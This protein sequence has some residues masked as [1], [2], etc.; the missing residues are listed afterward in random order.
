[1]KRVV[2]TG[3]G[4]VTALGDSWQDFR[5]ALET[6]TSA[7][8]KIEEWGKFRDFNTNL[9]GPVENFETPNYPRKKVRSMSRVSLMATKATE[10]ALLDAA[11]LDDPIIQSGAMGVS[12]GSCT[13]STEDTK[14]FAV[15]L[16]N[17][18]V[19]GATATTYIRMM[20]HT[21]PVNIGVFF[22]LKGR[23]IPTSSAC[24]SG[25]QGIGYAY[26][27]IK[28]GKQTL[29]AAGGAE[30]LCP[31][32]AAV[33]DSLYATSTK[34]DTPHL[35]PSPFDK[36]RDGLVIGEGAGTLILE[37]LDHALARGANIYAELVGFGTNS[38]GGHVTQPNAGTMKIAM[39]MALQ[40]ANLQAS[41]IG[42]INGHGTATD[43]GDIAE[44]R[45]TYEVFGDN[46]P[47]STLKGNIGHTLG[48]CGAIEAWAS[49]E[50]MRS[51]WIAPTL[52]LNEPDEACAALDYVMG[53][54]RSR[55]CEYIMSNNFAFG[56]INT[57]LIFKRWQ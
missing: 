51:G 8:R 23:V 42:Y 39:E 44:S 40:D 11:L 29:M 5:S 12:Y 49:I 45:A 21:A 27:A 7:I 48:A 31:S 32:E 3:M 35:T 22:G 54:G 26:E 14:N 53:E 16:S 50:M 57:S 47:F 1:M 18:D 46:V 52:N 30:E 10:A 6:R 41:D 28:Y 25:S 2:V 55:E 24:T 33:F 4:V 36:D 34:N 38:D 43:R 9:A 13:G 15:M 37:E 17:Y 20:S 19:G 56:G